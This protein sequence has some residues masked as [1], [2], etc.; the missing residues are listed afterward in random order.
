MYKIAVFVSGRGSNLRAVHHFESKK[1]T[2]TA[3]IGSKNDCGGV[4]F[5]KENGIPVYILQGSSF[6]DGISYANL[7]E[8]LKQNGVE[9]IVLAG[10]L[11]LIPSDF[12]SEF[13]NKIIN[14]HPALLPSFGGNG[15]YGINVHSA[16]FKS[17]AHVSGVTVH[18]VN[19]EYDMGLIIDQECVD[20]SNAQSPEQIAELVLKTEHKL[21]PNVINNFADDKIIIKSGRVY[22]KD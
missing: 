3:V 5:A 16:V 11:K 17:S 14:V 18:F 21:L 10:F 13:E 7:A 9:L 4:S 6:K 1:Y 19:N 22:L 15:M 8:I 20:I 12:V 2:I